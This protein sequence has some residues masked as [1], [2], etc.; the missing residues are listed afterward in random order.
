MRLAH[1]TLHNSRMVPK[2]GYWQCEFD[3]AVLILAKC[4]VIIVF[5]IIINVGFLLVIIIIDAGQCQ[6][7]QL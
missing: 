1:T 3:G 6:F 2:S 5:A 7:A 4:K